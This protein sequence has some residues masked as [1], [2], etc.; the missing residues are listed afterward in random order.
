MKLSY[1]LQLLGALLLFTAIV[2]MYLSI[3]AAGKANREQVRTMG[4]LALT[5]LIGVE[6]WAA[7][8]IKPNLYP[9]TRL[10]HYDDSPYH[11]IQVTEE[12]VSYDDKPE[13]KDGGFLIPC[14]YWDAP[15]FYQRRWLKFNENIESGTFPYSKKHL[16]AVT[17]TDLLHL[18]LIWNKEPKRILVVGGGGGIIPSQYS[19]WYNCKVDVAEIDGKVA[20][21]AQEYFDM[22]KKNGKL[23]ENIK[24]YIGDG[25]QTIRRDLKDMKYDVIMLDAYSSGGQIPFHLMTWNFLSEVKAKLAPNGI[26]ITNIISGLQNGT[27]SDSAHNADLF[28]TEYKTL[29][30]SRNEAL[31]LQSEDAADKAPLFKHLYVFPK[32]YAD[33]ESLTE[34]KLEEYRNVIVIATNEDKRRNVDSTPDSL[35]EMAIALSPRVDDLKEEKDREAAIEKSIVKCDLRSHIKSYKRLNSH[36]FPTIDTLEQFEVILTDDYAPVDLMYRPVKRDENSHR[37]R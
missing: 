22:P 8:P 27:Q 11:E 3:A 34:G 37:S 6:C 12:T 9:G 17:Y 25:R 32:F 13:F 33:D 1:V 15:M 26:L 18:P 14:K 21:V 10:I 28:L 31:G 20:D 4:M 36:R 7:F 24:F 35:E 23:N 29:S 2:C 19:N 5:L 30:A 16:N